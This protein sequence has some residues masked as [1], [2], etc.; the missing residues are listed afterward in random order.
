MTDKLLAILILLPIIW[1]LFHFIR[2][3]A[4]TFFR[5]LCNKEGHAITI[6]VFF[7]VLAVSKCIDRSLNV[8][9]ELYGMH[10]TDCLVALQ[11]SQEE[12][13]E[14]LLPVLI[15]VASWQYMQR[16]KWLTGF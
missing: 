1:M 8:L 10:F 4:G 7:V 3:H 6:L 2:N 15:I 16:R 5:E 12:F 9:T 14:C 13:L 11:L